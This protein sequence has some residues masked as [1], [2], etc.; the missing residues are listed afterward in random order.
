[1][2]IKKSVVITALVGPLLYL[3]LQAAASPVQPVIQQ[4]QQK[5]LSS[6]EEDDEF[7]QPTS[8]KF[9]V[10]KKTLSVVQQQSDKL[11]KEI[12]LFRRTITQLPQ[13]LSVAGTEIAH[14]FDATGTNLIKK[15]VMGIGFLFGLIVLFY[16]IGGTGENKERS[17][18][19]NT[20]NI[21]ELIFGSLATLGC[22]FFLLR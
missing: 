14:K 8:L 9:G 16:G 1:V 12:T 4:S 21:P 6:L 2:S 20:A 15:A 17:P 5:K 3:N 7:V 11:F 18:Q 10:G 19:K 22:G 13:K